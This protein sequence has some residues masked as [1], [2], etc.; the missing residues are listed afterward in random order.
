MFHDC[1][2]CNIPFIDSKLCHVKD[3][4]FFPNEFNYAFCLSA[5]YMFYS[6]PISMHYINA[7]AAE[8]CIEFDF[9]R[10]WL[11]KN[12]TLRVLVTEKIVDKM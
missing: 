9:K 2:A 10:T 11:G 12:P 4:S 3:V 5:N 6:R 7:N 1:C 8:Y